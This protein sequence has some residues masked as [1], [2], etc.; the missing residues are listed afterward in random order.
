MSLLAVRTV[1]DMPLTHV[2]DC[3]HL[4]T[5]NLVLSGQE[6]KLEPAMDMMAR[7]ELPSH[8]GTPHMI[9]ALDNPF[10]IRGVSEHPE[11]GRVVT[12]HKRDE[13]LIDYVTRTLSEYNSKQFEPR[14][15]ISNN[16]AY[17]QV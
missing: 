3:F 9:E 14:H 16:V 2:L 1:A 17:L 12:A 15:V 11:G 10:E 6:H 5:G 7:R 4:Q 13:E 8:L